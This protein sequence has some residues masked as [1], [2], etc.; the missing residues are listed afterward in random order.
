MNARSKLYVVTGV[1]R[2]GRA[3]SFGHG[4]SSLGINE[5]NVT[6]L[7]SYRTQERLSGSEWF[8]SCFGCFKSYC[9]VFKGHP[10]RKK[11]TLPLLFILDTLNDDE[12]N[13]EHNLKQSKKLSKLPNQIPLKLFLMVQ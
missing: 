2:T 5:R 9:V 4:R 13:F 1:E 10:V 6:I 8:Y 3:E 12:G 11:W 7:A